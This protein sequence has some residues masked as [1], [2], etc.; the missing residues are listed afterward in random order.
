MIEGKVDKRRKVDNR[1]E[2]KKGGQDVDKTKGSGCLC[3]QR[4]KKVEKKDKGKE[5]VDRMWIEGRK[6]D[7]NNDG[8]KEMWSRGKKVDKNKDKERK[9]DRMWITGRQVDNNKDRE[10]EKM[11][12]RKRSG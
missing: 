9:V 11:Y 3:G 8:E 6:V 4:E 5:K 7:N 10:K 12:R 2:R 1:I